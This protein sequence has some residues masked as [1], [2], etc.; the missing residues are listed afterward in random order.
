MALVYF[1]TVMPI[2]LIMRLLGKD[3][4]LQKLDKKA[5]SYWIKRT[6]PIGSMKNQF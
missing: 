3:L 2:G 6:I 1:S 5:K 4:L